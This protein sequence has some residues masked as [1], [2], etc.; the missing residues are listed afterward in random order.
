[1]S[2][3]RGCGVIATVPATPLSHVPCRTWTGGF[4]SPPCGGF[5]LTARLV[6]RNRAQ[7]QNVGR[8]GR[9]QIETSTSRTA[10]WGAMVEIAAE[11]DHYDSSI[12][13][14]TTAIMNEMADRTIFSGACVL[15]YEP[16]TIPGI[17]PSSRLMS[18]P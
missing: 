11:P 16:S 15:A 12:F 18:R 2:A 13:T 4:A 9:L 17:D 10:T 7:R 14:P 1:M 8:R 5:A 6:N 3:V